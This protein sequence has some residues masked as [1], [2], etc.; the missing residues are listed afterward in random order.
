MSEAEKEAPETLCIPHLRNP[1]GPPK[2]NRY[3]VPTPHHRAHSYLVLSEIGRTVSHDGTVKLL[4]IVMGDC[5]M[6]E[7]HGDCANS[8]PVSQ[9]SMQEIEKME[10][11]RENR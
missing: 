7:G 5:K 9:A 10:A 6:L 8:V 2:P 3:P 11:R 4:D 1:L